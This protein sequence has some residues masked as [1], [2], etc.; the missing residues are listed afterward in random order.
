[1]K[2]VCLSSFYPLLSVILPILF[3]LCANVVNVV[4]TMRGNSI[5]I[6][7]MRRADNRGRNKYEEAIKEKQR[8]PE[9]VY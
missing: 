6:I 5:R 3:F 7:S 8:E 2:T 4:Y 1:M 9:G